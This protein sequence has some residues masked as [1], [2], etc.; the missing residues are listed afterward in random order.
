MKIKDKVRRI[1]ED[2][3]DD[4]LVLWYKTPEVSDDESDEYIL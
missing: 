4:D 1:A 2:S 3:D